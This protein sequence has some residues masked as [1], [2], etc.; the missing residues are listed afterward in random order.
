[1]F[2]SH[3]DGSKQFLSPEVSVRVQEELGADIAMAFDECIPYPSDFAYTKTSTERTT[4]WAER[5]LKAHIREDQ[6]LFGI[7]QGGMFPELRKMSAQSL[8]DME[9]AFRTFR[10]RALERKKAVKRGELS[11]TEFQAWIADQM[12]PS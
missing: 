10:T 11:L 12:N 9:N 7:V 8:Q 6:A 3:I 4:R 2:R 1:M 5:C